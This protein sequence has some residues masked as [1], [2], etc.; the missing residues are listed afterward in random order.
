MAHASQLTAHTDKARACL[1][2]RRDDSSGLDRGR[3]AGY[4]AA[5]A[6]NAGLLLVLL[7]PMEVPPSA[8]WTEVIRPIQ[9]ITDKPVD[10][11]PVPLPI[12]PPAP[13]QA[14]TVATVRADSPPVP[15]PII[16]EGE[17]I[18]PDISTLPVATTRSTPAATPAQVPGMRL[19]YLQA[20]PPAYPRAA[21]RARSQGTVLLQVLVDIDGRPLRVEIQNSSG[22]RRLDQAAR[23]QVL[24][25]WRF[26]PAVQNGR[27][28]QALGLVP[29]MFNL[30]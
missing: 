11:P 18:A 2:C 24:R 26:R 1:D 8:G 23:D 30:R 25:H 3:I 19:E 28:V 27:A 7:T 12:Q 21:L 5:I 6:L 15:M 17:Q 13:H 10:P 22:D 9:W 4:T 16:A 29:V 20:S 14:Q